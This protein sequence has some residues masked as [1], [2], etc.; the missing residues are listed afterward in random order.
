MENEKT[1]KKYM[2]E[3]VDVRIDLLTGKVCTEMLA[4]DACEFFDDFGPAPYPIPKEYYKWAS[5]VVENAL[6]YVGPTSLSN[7]IV[8][9]AKAMVEKQKN[10]TATTGEWRLFDARGHEVIG[11]VEVTTDEGDRE[12][13]TIVWVVANLDTEEVYCL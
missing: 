4:G 10:A 5:E 7:K 3:E 1:V 9:T 12:F 11:A 8:A 2:M 6:S 13:S